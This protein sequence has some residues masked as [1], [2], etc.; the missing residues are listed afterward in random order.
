MLPLLIALCVIGRIRCRS[1]ENSHGS[2]DLDVKV[3]LQFDQRRSQF[4][5]CA[6]VLRLGNLVDP[7]ALPYRQTTE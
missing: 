3:A 1:L 5:F 2:R 7:A 4:G 6:L